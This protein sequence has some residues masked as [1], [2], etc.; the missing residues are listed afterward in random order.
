VLLQRVSTRWSVVTPVGLGLAAA[1]L[2]LLA[3]GLAGTL[4]VAG[5]WALAAG[6][7][8]LVPGLRGSVS[9]AAAVVVEVSLLVGL[10]VV[11]AKLSPRLHG[12]VPNLAILAAP[13]LV[14]LMLLVLA[15]WRRVP[16]S[17]P[18]VRSR[19]VVNLTV[20]GVVLAVTTWVAARGPAFGVAWAMSGDARNHVR[21]MRGIL[22]SGGLTIEQLRSYPAVIN[23]VASLFAGAT[24][25]GALAPGELML[26][27]AQAMATTYVLSVIGVA[28][29]LVGALL[30]MLPRAIAMARRLPAGVVVVLF[31]CAAASAS[32]LVLGTALADGFL[33]AYGSLPIALAAVVLALRCCRE[34]SPAAYALLGPATVLAL[35]GWTIIAAV[36]A[37]ATAVV[38]VVLLGQWLRTRRTTRWHALVWGLAAVAPVGA[39]AVTLGV[40][41]T[42]RERL[43]A[44]FLLPGTV[45]TPEPHVLLLL[46]LVAVGALVAAGMGAERLQL[47]V[48]VSVAV[49]GWVTIRV[50]RELPGGEPVWNYYSIK[51]LWLVA[52]CLV[53]VAFL[54]LL[55]VAVRPV[56]SSS[57]RWS[58]AARATQMAAWSVAVLMVLGFGTPVAEPVVKAA[59]GWYQPTGPSIAET[60]EAGDRGDPFL[61]WHWAD[62]GTDRLANFWAAAIWGSTAAGGYTSPDVAGWAYTETGQITDL[63]VMATA[64][65]GLS[66]I[67]Q[68][69][70]LDEQLDEACPGNTA[71]VLVDTT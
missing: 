42:Q 71:S 56:P 1:A 27:D 20:L 25:R 58:E 64:T 2:S 57:R 4:V 22:W 9:V 17:P 46:G 16:M 41:V 70:D 32:P 18:T 26:N 37:T 21:I 62:P 63:C 10:S 34:P 61:L 45:T 15:C 49:T 3:V 48:P 54:P 29:L 19:P 30:E 38:T 11:L 23:A 52:S 60:A 67:T 35:F 5:A 36:P 69:P 66:V 55:R 40:V 50:I 28:V 44:A 65:P 39:M 12:A 8:R 43:R 53:W 13:L 51:T 59:K 68:N 47:L 33:N 31:G 7:G 6:M 24:D 14:G